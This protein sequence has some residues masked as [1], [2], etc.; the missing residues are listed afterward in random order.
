[1]RFPKE[2]ASLPY[3]T[4]FLTAEGPQYFRV[5]HNKQ[6][7]LCRLCLKPGHMMKDCPELVCR[8]CCVP[9]DCTAE[10]Y[11]VLQEGTDQL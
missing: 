1:M 8:E 3:S 11:N 7:R 4:C 9:R 2:V 10:E 6:V 5:I